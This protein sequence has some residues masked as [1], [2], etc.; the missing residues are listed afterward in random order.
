VFAVL[1]ALLPWHAGEASAQPAAACEPVGEIAT[2]IETVRDQTTRMP[3][4]G[5]LVTASWPGASQPF[6]ARTD[7][8]GR[9]RICAPR[10]KSITL[11]VSYH[12]MKPPPQ[13]TWLSTSRIAEHT[14]LLDVPG[15]HLRGAVIE[16]AT[17]LAISNVH[18]RVG[19]TQLTALTNGSGLFS[20]ER[21]PVGDHTLRTEHIAYASVETLL[22]VR[23]DDLNATIRLTPAAIALQPVVVTA[24]SRR[25]E[26][27]GFY[28][29]QKR[30]IGIFIGRKQ[31]DAMNVQS[32]SDLLR[33]VPGNRSL[34]QPTRRNQS[35]NAVA[36][37][38]NCRYTFVVD[39]ARTLPDFD[40]DFVAPYAIEGV[41]I[42]QGLSEVPSD[43][44][45]YTGGDR[46][47]ICGV[48]V[49]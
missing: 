37:R 13:T 18:V 2:L 42:Y 48:V 7:S 5:A 38:G 3:L 6:R 28:E 43:F 30:G 12:A 9:V 35:R 19:N 46:S 8:S 16:Q 21:V 14:F 24:F 36:G 4:A 22:N 33:H 15:V 44:R 26:Q 20:F 47:A 40:M 32:A 27:A 25:L 34:P 45:T 1:T 31:V 49:I 11:R 39:G 10:A 23:D 17:G 29:R 41:E